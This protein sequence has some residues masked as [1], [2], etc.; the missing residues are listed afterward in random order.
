MLYGSWSLTAKVGRLRNPLKLCPTC[1][2]QGDFGKNSSRK[3]GL[4]TYCR[5]CLKQLQSY[6]K[7]KR[8][9][10]NKQKY[11]YENYIREA[12]IRRHEEST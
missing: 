1:G 4:Q 3:D 7:E 2:S 11:D 10:F 12:Y 8:I 6:S 9:L 5:K